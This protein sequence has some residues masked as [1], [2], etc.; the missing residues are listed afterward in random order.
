MRLCGLI[1]NI[2]VLY[3]T[4][5]I[6]FRKI[7]APGLFLKYLKYF[8]N[9]KPW[10][11]YKINS[12]KKCKTV[13][14]SWCRGTEFSIINLIYYLGCLISALFSAICN[15]FRCAISNLIVKSR[16]T[17]YI[18]KFALWKH[19]WLRKMWLIGYFNFCMNDLQ[20]LDVFNIREA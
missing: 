14:R 7:S 13:Q 3:F 1:W 16:F 18:C 10:C 4:N 2:I 5:H 11:S 15:C 12:L 8:V 6:F 17:S 19:C 9:F 20:M